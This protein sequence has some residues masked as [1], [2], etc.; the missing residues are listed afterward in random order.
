MLHNIFRFRPLNGYLA[1]FIAIIVHFYF[2]TRFILTNP[3]EVLIYVCCIYN[4]KEL[5]FVHFINQ[6]IIYNTTI[7]IKHHSVIYLPYWCIF[8]IVRK[9]I[10]HITFCVR[11]AYGN[12]PHVRHV[13]HAAIVAYSLMLTYYITILYGHVKPSKR[14]YHCTQGNMPVVK[15]S[16]FI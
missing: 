15:A 16:P 4:K 2:I 3:I 11:T 8:N 10:L 6:Q 12:L 9:Y 13:E 1:I 5:L 7:R 14:A